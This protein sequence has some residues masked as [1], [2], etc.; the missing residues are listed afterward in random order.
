MIKTHMTMNV[1]NGSV[2]ENAVIS[3]N[4]DMIIRLFSNAA[5]QNS[6]VTLNFDATT[7]MKMSGTY[8]RSGAAFIGINKNVP[9]LLT[10]LT[11]NDAGT[12]YV[13][14]KAAAATGVNMPAT[15]PTVAAGETFL[16]WAGA[17]TVAAAGAKYTNANAPEAG[18]ELTPFTVAS[19]DFVM[20]TGAG[21]RTADPIGIRFTAKVSDDLL[22]KI[23][24]SGLTATYSTVIAPNKYVTEAG[25]FVLED[26][27]D[28]DYLIATQTTAPNAADADAEGYVAYY[29]A[30]VGMDCSKAW[31]TMDFAAMGMLTLSDGTNEIVLYT[32][33]NTTDNVRSMLK[34]AQ[35]AYAA[36]TT[37][38][39][40]IN[41]IIA[42]GTAS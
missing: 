23:A 28:G 32:D 9:A 12:T 11:L 35:D 1:T 27:L 4:H 37:D 15:A 34:V 20:K 41:Q 16:G 36:G 17:G 18:V 5:S 29:A 38:N 8:A 22:A 33:F 13:V 24:D 2:L 42:V 26:M 7:K 21:I 3:D 10:T 31:V 30:L 25:G 6:N 40:L 14:G 19:D 39:A